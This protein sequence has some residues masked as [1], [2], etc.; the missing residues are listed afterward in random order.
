[1]QSFFA[2]RHYDPKTLATVFAGVVLTAMFLFITYN[3]YSQIVLG[4][5]G[6]QATATC[7]HYKT[8]TSRA[9]SGRTTTITYY[10][11]FSTADG[12]MIESSLGDSSL[13]L[14][15]NDNVPILYDPQ[16]PTRIC[17]D[18][19]VGVWGYPIFFGALGLV[20]AWGVWKG[21]KL[22]E[23]DRRTARE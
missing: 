8:K 23:I 16:R 18:S 19:F 22:R 1:M 20:L 17:R 6:Q 15:V 14:A 2:W 5:R 11:R 3:C 12:K 7:T 13:K 10:V 4:L 9:S 21:A